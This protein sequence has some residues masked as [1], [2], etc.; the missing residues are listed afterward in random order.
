MTTLPT[1]FGERVPDKW[2]VTSSLHF[3]WRT[4]RDA[5]AVRDTVK[6]TRLIPGVASVFGFFGSGREMT[7][8]C[9]RTQALLAASATA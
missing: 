8:L 4:Y 2:T 5:T 1:S 9:K 6:P 7:A 3:L